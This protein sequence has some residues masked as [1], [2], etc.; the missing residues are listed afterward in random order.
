[1]DRIGEQVTPLL[2]SIK[3][4]AITLGVCERTVWTLTQEREL[5]HVRIGR[6]VL[7]S[8][9]ALQEWITRQEN[10]GG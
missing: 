2:L 6:R 9:T 8:R 7:F 3:E 1:M 5:P 10:A 4:A